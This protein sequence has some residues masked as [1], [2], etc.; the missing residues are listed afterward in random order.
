[1][2]WIVPVCIFIIALG[3]VALWYTVVP[4]CDPR[5]YFPRDIDGTF[6]RVPA[7]L[8]IGIGSIGVCLIIYVVF[9]CLQT[10]ASGGSPITAASAGPFLALL[11]AYGSR[12]YA[13]G[14]VALTDTEV[15]Y[16][17][18][19]RIKRLDLARCD[20]VISG[21]SVV[22][23]KTIDK[24]WVRLPPGMEYS[25]RFLGALRSAIVARGSKNKAEAASRP[26]QRRN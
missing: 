26:G 19:E 16:R 24:Q 9:E 2:W 17:M 8:R 4:I 18:G 7:W 11:F 22:G 20:E 6:Y 10:A 15:V 5:R 13:R 14:F 25:G 3:I 1:M 21:T 12:M 23:I